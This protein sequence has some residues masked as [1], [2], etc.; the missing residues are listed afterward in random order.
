[1]VRSTSL[2][3]G[4]YQV[5]LLTPSLRSSADGLRVPNLRSCPDS[6]GLVLYWILSPKLGP[7]IGPIGTGLLLSLG[8]LVLFYIIL[9]V[10]LYNYLYW[11]F[12]HIAGRTWTLAVGQLGPFRRESFAGC[13]SKLLLSLRP[14]RVPWAKQREEPRRRS[15]RSMRPCSGQGFSVSVSLTPR[16]PDS[17]WRSLVDPLGLH[18]PASED[19]HLGAGPACIICCK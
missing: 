15:G 13:L 7:S 17:P 18:H 11:C 1:M 19:F 10:T 2:R 6:R 5:P 16:S 4:D 12:F 14:R 9:H 3:S 8:K